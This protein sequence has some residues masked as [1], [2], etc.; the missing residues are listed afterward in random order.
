MP[1]ALAGA[2]AV[3][4]PALPLLVAYSGGADSTALLLACAERWPGQVRAVHVHHG[5]QSAADD[6]VRHC[7]AFCEALNV[8]LQVHHVQAKH[9]PGESPEDAA[10]IARYKALSAA[11]LS[12]SAHGAIESIALAQHADDQVE[13]LLLA[14]SRGAGLPGLSAMPSNWQRDGL[15]YYR[16]FLSVPAA[17]IRRWLAARAVPF[18]EDP[19]NTDERYTRNR[20]RA[21]LL[22]V[23]EAAFPQFRATFAR[24]AANAAQAQALLEEFAQQDLLVTG[25]PPT[26]AAM[27]SLPANRQGNLLRYWLKATYGVSPSASQLAE[28]LRQIDACA[29]RGHKIHIKLGDGFLVR[30]GALLHW[31]NPQAP[32]TTA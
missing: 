24:S 21:R 2:M 26:I 13:T 32:G 6:F 14:L 30:Q 22:P 15:R 16:P 12:A 4:A 17:D 9:A 18:V 29:T 23:L 1:P 27:R 11:A 10:R 19:S 5:L 8:P 28:A 25:C 7:Q 3:F 31:Y 20:I